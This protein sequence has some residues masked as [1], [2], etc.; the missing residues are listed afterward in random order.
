MYI[1]IYIILDLNSYKNVSNT[2]KLVNSLM[3]S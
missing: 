1:I 2:K 3:Y